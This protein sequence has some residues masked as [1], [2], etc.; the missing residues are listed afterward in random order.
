MTQPE[1]FEPEPEP[2]P[3]AEP[4][5]GPSGAPGEGRRAGSRRGRR[6]GLWVLL[7]TSLMALALTL[8]LFALI[9]RPV[10][11]P[12]W[13]ASRAELLLSRQLP[14]M[15]L[16]IGE[17]TVVIEDGLRPRIRARALQLRERQSSSAIELEEVDITLSLGDLLRRRHLALQTV[18]VTGVFVSLHRLEDGAFNI[19]FGPADSPVDPIDTRATLANFGSE[20]AALFR[21]PLLA[22]L[23]TVRVDALHLRYEDVRAGRGW[24]I[25]G[26]QA[27]LR[28]RGDEVSIAANMVALGARSYV[29]SV[30]MTVETSL[31]TNMSHFGLR[32]EDMPAGEI[33]SQS[34]ALAWLAILKAPISGSLRASTRGDG[35]LGPTAVA[36]QIGAGALQPDNLVRPVP[37]SRAHTYLTYDPGSQTLTLDEFALQADLVSAVAQGKAVL[38]EMDQGIPSQMVVQLEFTK[39]DV[40][41]NRLADSPIALES[42][43]ADFRLRLDPFE[44]SLGQLVLTQKGQRLSLSGHMAPDGEVWDYGLDG[45]MTRLE[46]QA[47]LG[48]WPDGVKPRLREWIDR[49]VEAIDLSDINLALRSR[50]QEPP[51]VYADFQFSDLTLRFMKTMPLLQGGRGSAVLLHNQFMVGADAGYVVADQGGRLDVTGTRF[52]VRDTT[53]KEAP[54]RVRLMAEGPVTAALSLLNRAPL[55]VMDKA[56]LPV[57]LAS[58]RVRGAGVLDLVLK[59]KILPADVTFDIDLELPGIKTRHFIKDKLIAGDLTGRATHERIVLQGSGRVGQVPMQAQWRSALGPGRDGS[60]LVTGQAELGAR[61]AAEFGVGF[62]PETFDGSGSGDFRIEISRAAPPRLSLRSDLTGLGLELPALGWSKPAAQSGTLE[63]DMT[64]ARPPRVDRFDF[65]APGLAATGDVRLHAQGGLDRVTLG[66]F[67]VGNW[68]SGTGEIVGRGADLAPEFLLTSGSF[69][70]RGLPDMTRS[71]GAQASGPIRASLQRVQISDS[72]FLKDFVGQFED[73]G[74]LTGQFSGV[75]NGMA[76]VFGEMV[77]RNGRPA[78]RVT[79]N[80]G[81]DVINALGMARTSGPGDLLL[82]LSPGPEAA[83]YDGVMSIQNV[84]LLDAPVFAELLNAISVVGLLEQ[85]SGPG[86][87]LTEIATKFRLSPQQLTIF[88]GSAVGPGM[89]LSAEGSMNLSSGYMELQGALSPVYFLNSVGRVISKKGEGLVAFNYLARGSKDDLQISVNP[90]SALTPGFLRGIFRAPSGDGA[91]RPAPANNDPAS[92]APSQ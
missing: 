14:H 66:A 49:N 47:V 46:K 71:G 90:L 92:G 74:G 6:V 91:A 58:G 17:M 41:P 35:V 42:A 3:S 32:F 34:P 64:L 25:D 10:N 54:A 61:A 68:L 86:I 13:M 5:A 1:N 52:V 84:K 21:L 12:G 22:R 65:E 7:S 53:L 20:L 37:F 73:R 31:A 8:V 56:R 16:S 83:T 2:G 15:D 60:S 69:D 24:S 55:S 28:R 4:S 51:D 30:E 67:E 87:L 81:G 23:E 26:G 82:H 18:R 79:S 89:G 80:R 9:G 48:V 59:K 44:L 40:N 88:E 39:L 75:F 72:F 78:F 76:P 29:S 11:V 27:R 45:A 33:A 70:V 19:T 85:L 63:V 77:P 38:G 43:F 50:R 57:D 62:P 36:L